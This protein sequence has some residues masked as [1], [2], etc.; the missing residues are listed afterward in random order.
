MKSR[1]IKRADKAGAGNIKC[2]NVEVAILGNVFSRGINQKYMYE[3]IENELTVYQIKKMV[4]EIGCKLYD[5]LDAIQEMLEV[6]KKLSFAELQ[7][8]FNMLDSKEKIVSRFEQFEEYI[9]NNINEVKTDRDIKRI[10]RMF[11]L[12]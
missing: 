8:L 5:E 1:F 10:K 12:G 4:Y 2:G 6:G 9:K 7:E 11:K 3:K